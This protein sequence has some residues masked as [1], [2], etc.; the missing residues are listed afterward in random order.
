VLSRT[1]LSQ[2]FKSINNYAVVSTGYEVSIRLHYR[3]PLDTRIQPR[4]C[5]RQCPKGIPPESRKNQ[6]K[7]TKKSVAFLILVSYYF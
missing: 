7:N 6:I 3:K 4:R 5:R 2:N 1:P